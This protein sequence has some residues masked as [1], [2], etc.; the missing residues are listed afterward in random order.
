[1]DPETLV[2]KV[3]FIDT[4]SDYHHLARYL[5]TRIQE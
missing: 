1:V 2:T 3:R 4:N 5:E